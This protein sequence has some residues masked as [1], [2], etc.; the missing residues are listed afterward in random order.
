MAEVAGVSRR[1]GCTRRGW[2]EAGVTRQWFVR[3]VDGRLMHDA[4]EQLSSKAELPDLL[5]KVFE[6]WRRQQGILTR[7]SHS[8][9]LMITPMDLALCLVTAVQLVRHAAARRQLTQ[10][11]LPS[12]LHEVC[13]CARSCVRVRVCDDAR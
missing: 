1:G 3:G 5:V 7:R 11:G 13:A 4:C 12:M 9:Q 10:R 8:T 2:R 6:Y